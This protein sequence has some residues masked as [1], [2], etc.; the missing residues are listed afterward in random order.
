MNFEAGYPFPATNPYS[1]RDGYAA[2][3]KIVSR[4]PKRRHC[5][6]L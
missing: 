6:L 4:E 3:E 1:K 2:A 5:W